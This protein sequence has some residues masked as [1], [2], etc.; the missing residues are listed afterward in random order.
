[1]SWGL[2][3]TRLLS[4]GGER[5]PG[6]LCSV[7]PQQRHADVIS[8][9]VAKPLPLQ[10]EAGGQGGQRGQWL[11]QGEIAQQWWLRWDLKLVFLTPNVE[12]LLLF[13]STHSACLPLGRG[14]AGKRALSLHLDPLLWEILLPGL[15]VGR[16]WWGKP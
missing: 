8:A 14:R 2:G 5:A 11:A 12:P 10:M 9:Q 1:M 6:P 16:G 15:C 4:W 7:D 13:H 3:K